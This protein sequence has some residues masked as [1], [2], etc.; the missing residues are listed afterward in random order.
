MR[1]RGSRAMH[2]CPSNHSA[3]HCAG[4]K[5]GVFKYRCCMRDT[6]AAKRRVCIRACVRARKSSAGTTKRPSCHA[7]TKQLPCNYARL[8]VCVCICVCVCVCACV[9]A[10]V[11]VCVC[12]F[13]CVYV[14]VRARMCVCVCVSVCVYVCVCPTKHQVGVR[15]HW[16]C[17]NI[18]WHAAKRHQECCPWRLANRQCAGSQALRIN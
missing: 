15:R 8:L 4:I 1:A 13:V 7:S 16:L 14:C 18:V 2:S 12:V 5:I 17:T 10:C 9:C 11:C 6:I 3:G